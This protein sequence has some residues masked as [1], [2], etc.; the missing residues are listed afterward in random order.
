[1][2]RVDTTEAITACTLLIQIN[3]FVESKREICDRTLS[4]EPELLY[5]G[6]QVPQQRT[7]TSVRNGIITSVFLHYIKPNTCCICTYLGSVII[8]EPIQLERNIIF[9]YYIFKIGY[10]RMW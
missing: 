8:F 1:M 4:R 5:N 3:Y 9:N 10:V 6:R 7:V 2:R